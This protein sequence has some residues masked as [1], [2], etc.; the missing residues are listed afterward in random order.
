MAPVA[1]ANLAWWLSCLPGALRWRLAAADV[2]RA[3]ARVLE[4]ILAAGRG[5]RFGREHRLGEVRSVAEYRARVPLRR[6]EELAPWVVA[7]AGG[8]ADVL[9]PGTP[10]CFC[11]TSGSSAPSKLIPHT[12]ALAAEFQAGIAPWIFAMFARHPALLRGR[13]YWSISPAGP[14]PPAT[15][16]GIPVGLDDDTAYFGPLARRLL[17]T[18]MAVPPAVARLEQVDAFRYATLAFLLAADDLAFVSVWNPSFLTLLLQPLPAWAPRLADDLEQGRLRFPAAVPGELARELSRGLGRHPRR[19]ARIRAALRERDPAGRTLPER[20]WPRLSL[21]SCWCDAAA[22]GPA[23]ALRALFPRVPLSA[24]GLL[25]TEGIVSFPLERGRGS[26]LALGSHFLEFLPADGGEARCAWE[27][28]EGGR[29]RVALTTGGGLYRYLL[30]DVVEV[31]GFFGRCAL[32]TFVGRGDLVSD[33][34]GEKLNEDHVLA[35]LAAAF[36][37]VAWLPGFSLLAPSRGGGADRYLLHVAADGP[38]PPGALERI[39]ARLEAGLLENVHYAHCRR[40]GQLAEAAVAWREGGAAAAHERY[41]SA[42][43]ARGQRAGDV[44]PPGLQRG[45]GWEQAL[46]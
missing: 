17:A 37:A 30:G 40:L 21:I 13:A 36:A 23:E 22:R 7:A 31:T 6:W 2:E 27:L 20:L 9:H 41:Q 38:P 46:G 42:C 39:G 4:R 29:Y 1:P 12:P 5:T 43:R 18:V 26:A 33:L 45:S 14:R 24:K 15:A 44:K 10:S 3:Q 16:A 32:V 8:E 11:P 35:V 19:A 34:H 25:A 28:R